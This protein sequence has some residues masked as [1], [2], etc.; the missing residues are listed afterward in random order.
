MENQNTQTTN[1]IQNSS[2]NSTSNIQTTP[3]PG[4]NPQK[5]KFMIILIGFFVLFFVTLG[6]AAAIYTFKEVS[7]NNNNELEQIPSITPQPSTEF[8]ISPAPT[9]AQPTTAEC[10]MAGC[11]GQLCVNKGQDEGLVTT[12]EYKEE[13][14]CYKTATCEVQP[15]G[16]CG[17]TPSPQLLLCLGSAQ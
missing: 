10:V 5:R 4:N 9:T 1:P 11:S 7:R 8:E 12:C 2:A 14:A 16:K 3:P 17:W 13:Y 6:T 15:N